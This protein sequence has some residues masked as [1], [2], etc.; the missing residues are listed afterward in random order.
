MKNLTQDRRRRQ[1]IKEKKNW[2]SFHLNE[3][4]DEQ[5]RLVEE[6][7]LEEGSTAALNKYSYMLNDDGSYKEPKS[8]MDEFSIHM[9]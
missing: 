8:F 2:R 7:I 4:L 9:H 1:M 5:Q 6:G 3:Q